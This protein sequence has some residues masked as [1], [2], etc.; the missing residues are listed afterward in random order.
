MIWQFGE[1]GYDYSINYC[2]DGTIDES[3]RTYPK[4]IEWGYVEQWQRN[5]LFRVYQALIALKNDY[6]VFSTDDY[7][8][9]VN[10]FQKTITLNSED[11]KVAVLGNFATSAA[12][13]SYS[14]AEGGYWYEFFTGDS[15]LAGDFAPDVIALEAGEYRLY[16][17][18]KIGNGLVLSVDEKEINSTSLYVYPNP[19]N[20]EFI[21][22]IPKAEDVL[23]LYIYSN[24][25]VM[26]DAIN[27]A[28]GIDKVTWNAPSTLPKG[29]YLLKLVSG[30]DSYTTRLIL[31]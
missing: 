3:C 15:L 23:N 1:L 12:D 31:K 11:M 6:P 9:N 14:F 16:T 24:T 19:G 17:N 21:I 8:L 13:I 22:D 30:N 28:P 26:I 20:G 5:K 10:G 4:P 29:L 27:I 25:G 18:V 7:S 2:Q